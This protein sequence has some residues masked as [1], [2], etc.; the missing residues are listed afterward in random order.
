MLNS[1]QWNEN[2][3]KMEGTVLN[4]L[5]K[6]META[7]RFFSTSFEEQKKSAKWNVD[8]QLFFRKLKEVMENMMGAL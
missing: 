7:L 4:G 5:K 8:E 6:S 2:P 1:P 3:D